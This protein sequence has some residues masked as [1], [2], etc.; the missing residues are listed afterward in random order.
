MWGQ[1]HVSPKHSLG[2]H[3]C[4]VVPW[5]FC[6]RCRMCVGRI[7]KQVVILFF[8]ESLNKEQD[9]NW[10]FCRLFCQRIVYSIL[11]CFSLIRWFNS[12]IIQS[13]IT[14]LYSLLLLQSM[15]ISVARK[16]GAHPN[17]RADWPTSY[18][19]FPVSFPCAHT[20]P[21]HTGILIMPPYYLHVT[22]WETPT[23]TIIYIA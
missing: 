17:S 1:L 9:H 22:S 10:F 6:W 19:D 5:Y 14:F 12:R 20:Y 8:L 18:L 7:L 11:I 13:H 3:V 23:L 15:W 16:P 4:L 2:F 21:H